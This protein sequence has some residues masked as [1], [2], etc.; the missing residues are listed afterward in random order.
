MLKYASNMHKY[1]IGKYAQI[2][3]NMQKHAKYMQEKCKYMQGL[4]I[5]L[6]CINARCMHVYAEYA[7]KDIICSICTYMHPPLC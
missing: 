3:T 6:F 5:V 2:C 4:R 7:S 1:A